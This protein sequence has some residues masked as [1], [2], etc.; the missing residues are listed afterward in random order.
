[1]LFLRALNGGGN[2]SRRALRQLS[3]QDAEGTARRVMALVIN[4]VLQWGQAVAL[5]S[6]DVLEHDLQ[7]SSGSTRHYMFLARAP[8]NDGHL[9]Y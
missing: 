8:R 4:R 3:H 7:D 5:E 6:I 1:V 9:P 2:R